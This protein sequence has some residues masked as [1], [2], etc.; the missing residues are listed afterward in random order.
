MKVQLSLWCLNPACV[1]R[2]I[3]EQ[4]RCVIVTSGTLSP[5]V[6]FASELGIPFGTQ[7]E[8]KHVVPKQ[9]VRGCDLAHACVAVHAPVCIVSC[10]QLVRSMSDSWVPTTSK[11]VCHAQAHTSQQ[12]WFSTSSQQSNSTVK[13]MWLQVLPMAIAHSPGGELLKATFEH[14]SRDRFQ[15][16]VG[17]A[18]LQLARVVPDGMLVFMPSYGMMDKLVKRWKDTGASEVSVSGFI[19]RVCK[20]AGGNAPMCALIVLRS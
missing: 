10:L 4:A 20:S 7:L 6:S 5:M 16:G 17:D 2:E 11:A 14:S 18:L 9:N 3:G 19:V 12:C 15:D 13:N 1:F 8:T